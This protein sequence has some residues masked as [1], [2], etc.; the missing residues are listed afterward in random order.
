MK[1]DVDGNVT[2]YKAPP[3]PKG[4]RQIQGVEY[5]DIFARVEMLKYIRILL[6]IMHFTIIKFGRWML[7]LHYSIKMLRKSCI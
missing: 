2:V 7:R 6:E 4:F 1:T 5:D 3:V